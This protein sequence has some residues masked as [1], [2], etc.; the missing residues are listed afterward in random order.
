MNKASCLPEFSS[1]QMWW[2][3]LGEREAVGI[4]TKEGRSFCVLQVAPTTSEY[5]LP[6][7]PSVFV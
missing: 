7:L 1:L 4:S 2:G 3:N 6:P 5:L